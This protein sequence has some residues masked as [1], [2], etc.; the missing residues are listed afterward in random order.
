[1]N[2]TAALRLTAPTP[3]VNWSVSWMRWSDGWM[4]SVDS[5]SDVW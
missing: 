1:M 3:H 2:V 4:D 5:E